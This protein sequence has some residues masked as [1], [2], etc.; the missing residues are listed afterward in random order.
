LFA[1]DRV[2]LHDKITSMAFVSIKCTV[3]VTGDR[4][5]NCG[6]GAKTSSRFD[7]ARPDPLVH[8][9]SAGHDELNYEL[10]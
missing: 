7:R 5:I 3:T 9:V 8:S 6:D 2:T 4:K 10:R 1:R